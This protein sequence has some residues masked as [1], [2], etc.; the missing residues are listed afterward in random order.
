MKTN[1]FN[2]SIL[3]LLM[4]LFF[5]SCQIETEQTI[6]EEG[7]PVSLTFSYRLPTIE[8]VNMTKATAEQETTLE[9]LAMLFYR[10]NYPNDKPIIV[11]V[12]D[13]QRVSAPTPTN[14][15]YSVTLS[16][17]ELEAAGVMS[18]EWYLYAIGN[19]NKAFCRINLDDT[20][21]P[22]P[23][24][25]MTRAQ[26]EDY[27]VLKTSSTL[28]IVE[29][30]ILM[31]GRY[32]T[33]GSI[34]LVEG[35]NTLSQT[36]HL[37]RIVSK[38][39]FTFS[40]HS[41]APTGTEFRATSIGIYNYSRSSSLFER[42]GW[43]GTNGTEPG[44]L[45]Y[46]AVSGENAYNSDDGFN[47]YGNTFEFY[48]LEHIQKP[49]TALSSWADREVKTWDNTYTNFTF[50]NSPEKATYV[51]VKGHFKGPHT[52]T[53]GSTGIYEGDVEYTI[54]L[55]DFSASGSNSNFTARRNVSYN[56]NIKV[57]GVN[58]IVA[59]VTTN[60]DAPGAE[61]D[62]IFS[63]AANV[64]NVDSH[65]E[66][67]LLSGPITDATASAY[68][69]KVKTPYTNGVLIDDHHTTTPQI[70]SEHINWI[71]FGKP[72]SATTFAAYNPSN[73]VDIYTLIAELDEYGTTPNSSCHYIVTS[74]GS[75]SSQT[76]TY[77]VAAYVDEYYYASQPL[78]SFVNAADR[79]I[80]LSFGSI[81]T[82]VDK[83]SSFVDGI[84]FCISQ[85]SIVSVM[86]L[87]EANPFG[88]E[89]IEEVDKATN[90]TQPSASSTSDLNGWA[91]F[92]T[93][94]L[95]TSTSK[96]WSSYVNIA[97]NGI[98][99][100]T[101]SRISGN[102]AYDCLVRNRDENGDGKI[103]QDE[104]KWYLPAIDQCVTMWFGYNSIPEFA[105]FHN[106]VFLYV[107]STRDKYVWWVDEGTAFG[108]RPGSNSIRTR[109]VRSL[110]SYNTITTK[111]HSFNSNS[112]VISLSGLSEG[113]TREAGT[114]SGEYASHFRGEV[115]DQLPIDF[116]VSSNYLSVGDKTR[117]THDDVKTARLCELNYSEDA[118]GADLGEWR[119]PNEKELYVMFASLGKSSTTN[120]LGLDDRTASRSKYHRSSGD[121]VVYYVIGDRIS[122]DSDLGGGSYPTGERFRIRCVRDYVTANANRY[123]SSYENGGN[124]LGL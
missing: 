93:M 51:V 110:K 99:G 53:D 111:V 2:I 3:S 108:A 106:D 94:V 12:A 7:K 50:T 120:T 30:A 84:E 72:A 98:T 52:K 55:G 27:C 87:S 109:C 24:S 86:D 65:Y 60:T 8:D 71:K 119:I 59:E 20:T 75:G 21:K 49:E 124:G 88:V 1:I 69:I 25:Q 77:H 11:K 67:V 6:V 73:V 118:G 76:Y 13:L 28:D 9:S 15:I 74:Q 64:F 45:N 57:K 61:G 105:L 39:K 34:T 101:S 117:F 4:G 29:T 46:K 18:G 31:T 63:Q 116:Q 89:S 14:Y 23:L 35:E 122:T 103:T 38:Q 121:D 70:A 44:S 82:S 78:E 115:P 41:D 62:I 19:Y 92:K 104:I 90:V 42:S 97:N 95:G 123:D 100:T 107:N 112:N 5:V 96:N 79:E 54:H 80:T 114:I 113:A 66:Q 83:H 48:M 32:G 17:A 26:L 33:D 37:K 85:K 58:S 43:I 81:Q 16:T 56:Y 91:N 68:T 36:L 47:V 40:V 102:K 10:K 22:D